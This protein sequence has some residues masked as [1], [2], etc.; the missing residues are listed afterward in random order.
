MTSLRPALEILV[1]GDVCS[2]TLRLLPTLP[3]VVEVRLLIRAETSSQAPGSFPTVSAVGSFSR[4]RHDTF[5]LEERWCISNKRE[6]LARC[7]WFVWSRPS[8]LS[9]A[10]PRHSVLCAARQIP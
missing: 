8:L 9:Q 5:S 1:V 6:A 10:A 2:S 7:V 4:T 3:P